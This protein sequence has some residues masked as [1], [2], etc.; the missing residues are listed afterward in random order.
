M[1]M[2]IVWTDD[3]SSSGLPLRLLAASIYLQHVGYGLNEKET[4]SD[5]MPE[6]RL[7]TTI[8]LRKWL[9]EGNGSTSVLLSYNLEFFRSL[10]SR[11]SQNIDQRG[12]LSIKGQATPQILLP[13]KNHIKEGLSVYYYAVWC[14]DEPVCSATPDN[15]ES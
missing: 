12:F 4:N 13:R 11:Q 10:P 6:S 3:F 8:Y 15:F 1:Q 7:I 2:E 14:G 9:E 5:E